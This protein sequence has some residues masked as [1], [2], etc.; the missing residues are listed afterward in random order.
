MSTNNI[1]VFIEQRSGKVLPASYQLL[2]V[3]ADLA[4]KTGGQAEACVV[5]EGVASTTDNVAAYGAKKIYTVDGGDF[6]MYSAMPYVTATAAVIDRA[7][8]K[9]VL[10]PTS[11]MGRD[12]AARVAARQR[13]ALAIDCTEVDARR[14][15]SHRAQADVRRQV[16]R[17]FPAFREAA[18]G[19]DHSVECVPGHGAAIRRVRPRWKRWPSR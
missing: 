1:L 8:P 6:G 5:G 18:A 3:A 12:L 10:F 11:A 7:D 17:K 2:A 14:R 9:M 19:G 4:G 16:Q 13:A 15:G